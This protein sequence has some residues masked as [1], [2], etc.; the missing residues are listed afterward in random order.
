M[1]VI[2]LI[3]SLATQTCTVETA[4]VHFT[5][6][7]DSSTPMGCFSYGLQAVARNYDGVYDHTS[8]RVVIRCGR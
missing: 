4:R 1:N 5:V 3:C 2:I 6:A 7:S 8:E